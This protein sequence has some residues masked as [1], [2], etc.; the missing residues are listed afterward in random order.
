MTD[1]GGQ[2]D[3]WK[4]AILPGGREIRIIDIRV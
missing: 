4:P 3:I 1:E 2:A